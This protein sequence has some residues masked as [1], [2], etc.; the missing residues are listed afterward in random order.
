ML[1][2][3][4]NDEVP[5][6]EPEVHGVDLSE[7]EDHSV[8]TTIDP[9]TGEFVEVDTLPVV[10]SE[11]VNGVG[12]FNIEMSEYRSDEGLANSELQIFSRNPSS[13]VWS[14]TAPTDITKVYDADFGTSLHTKL[15]EPHLYE[16]T[17][18]VSGVK[19]RTAQ[20]FVEMQK[21]NPDMIVLTESEDKQIELMAKSAMS[22]PMFARI[23]NAEGICEASIFVDDPNTGLRLKIRP[24]KVIELCNPPIFNDVKTTKDIDDWRNSAQ[25]KNP[26]FNIGYGFTAAYYLYVGSIHYGVE[27]DRYNFCVVSKSVSMSRYPVSVFTVTKNELVELGFWDEMLDTLHRFAEC[28]KNNSFTSYEQFP[29]FRIY[30]DDNGEIEVTYEGGE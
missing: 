23:M 26:L 5:H 11:S 29:E 14:K 13:Y 16:D 7:Y 9:E 6:P 28:K 17:T 21:A 1:V 20:A 3:D 10:E 24:D 22:D 18:I 12:L 2:L 25:W 27:L 30:N 4:F 8:I 19:G 15:L